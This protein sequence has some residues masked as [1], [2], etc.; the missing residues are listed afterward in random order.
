M[1]N[2]DKDNF[3]EYKKLDKNKLI[4]FLKKNLDVI[5][6]TKKEIEKNYEL[7]LSKIKEKIKEKIKKEKERKEEENISNKNTL[8]VDETKK[9]ANKFKKSKSSL[10]IYHSNK[11]NYITQSCKEFPE[12]F[13]WD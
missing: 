11:E 9:V 6:I 10:Y 7:N 3:K 2:L 13:E 1:Y 12:K 5:N 8:I 4:K